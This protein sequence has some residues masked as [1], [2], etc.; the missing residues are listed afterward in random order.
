[1]NISESIAPEDVNLKSFNLALALA[2]DGYE[3][4]DKN[5]H[6]YLSS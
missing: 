6:K 5:L 3:K 1:M 4:T 2:A